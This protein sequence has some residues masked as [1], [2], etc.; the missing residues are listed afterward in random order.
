MFLHRA[1]PSPSKGKNCWARRTAAK[2]PRPMAQRSA[3]CPVPPSR[4]GK[5]P[6]EGNLQ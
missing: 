5:S 4:A 6:G 3:A 2:F 1:G